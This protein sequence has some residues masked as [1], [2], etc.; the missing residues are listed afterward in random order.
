[1]KYY[2]TI[3]GGSMRET[4]ELGMSFTGLELQNMQADS[5]S[6]RWTRR[7]VSEA[8]PLVHNDTVE[9]YADERRIF[10]G[11]VRLGTVTSEGAGISIVGPWS[12]LEEQTYQLSLLPDSAGTPNGKLLGETFT[13]TW[14]AGN[15]IWTGSEWYTLPADH[16]ITMTMATHGYYAGY[17]A[18]AGG[19]DVNMAWTARGWLF[20]PNSAS[21]YTTISDEWFRLMS[22][23]SDTNPTAVPFSPGTVALG[24]ALAPR[25]RTITDTLVS[26]ALRQVLA[27]KPDAAVWWDYS[28]AGLPRINVRVASL[29][30]AVALEIGEQVL[31]NYQLKAT[32]ELVPAGVVVR[33]E[34]DADAGTGLGKPY[35][36]DFYPGMEVVTGCATATSSNEVTCSSTASLVTGLMVSGTHV[37]PGATITAILSA[38]KF[39]ISANATGTLGGQRMI[40]RAAAGAACH[41]PGM[42][43][44]TVTD[45]IKHVPGIAKEVYH[46]LAVRRAQGSLTVV[47]RDFTLGLRPGMVISLS[48]DPQLAGIQLWVQ[49]VSWNPATGLAQLTVGYPVHLQLRD[50][51]DLKGWFKMSFTGVFGEYS[52]WIVP[53]P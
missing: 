27:M 9:I 12:H 16:V 46:S 28:G 22:F 10:R 34:R 3:N 48:G 5:A 23:M 33:W 26:D 47:D 51:V 52:S 15:T 20:R 25:V 36:A 2:I 31:A 39:R 13:Q 21:I 17:P 49:S 6:L 42:L 38:T 4:R 35:L 40:F 18:T 29:E 24:A 14:A 1:M 32:D 11:R 45:E 43:L 30:P 7:R 53:A 37:P 19:V 50:R 44:H 8:C 41:K